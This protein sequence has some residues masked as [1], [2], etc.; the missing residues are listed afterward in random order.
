MER[1]SKDTMNRKAGMRSLLLGIGISA[2]LVAG[3][4]KVP[5][6][7]LAAAKASVDEARAAG[8][9]VYAAKELDIAVDSLAAAEAEIQKQNGKFALFRSYKDAQRQLTVAQSLG[10]TAKDAAISGKA[11]AKEEAEMLIAQ[12]KAAVDSTRALMPMAPRDKEG[13]KIME[14]MNADLESVAATIPELDDKMAKEDYRGAA[15]LARGSLQRVEGIRKEIQD[16]IDR[17]AGK[18]PASTGM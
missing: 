10:V 3:C 1:R 13:K 11:K 18:M 14:A 6:T 2:L 7:E 8:G 16:A 12:V 17:K 5:E 9:E 4:G 15:Q